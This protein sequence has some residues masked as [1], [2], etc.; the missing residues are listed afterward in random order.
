[1]RTSVLP[2]SCVQKSRINNIRRLEESHFCSGSKSM[3]FLNV[4]DEIKNNIAV[5]SSRK[6]L[7]HLSLY[8]FEHV[9]KVSMVLERSKVI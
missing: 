8:E 5:G 7:E 4:R 6:S 3:P 9:S 1:M 2:R